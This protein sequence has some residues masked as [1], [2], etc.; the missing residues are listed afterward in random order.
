ML[1]I[2]F[3]II[4]KFLNKRSIIEFSFFSFNIFSFLF[5]I[6]IIINVRNC[7]YHFFEEPR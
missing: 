4:Y 6:I 3:N 5:Y 2:S 7:E 1:K